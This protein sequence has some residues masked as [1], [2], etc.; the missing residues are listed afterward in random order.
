MSEDELLDAMRPGSRNPR[1][2]RDSKDLGR[3]GLGLK[4]A[5]LRE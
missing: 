5:A 3:F 2:E 4:T 1:D